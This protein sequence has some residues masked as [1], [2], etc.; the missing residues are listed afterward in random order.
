M[1]AAEAGPSGPGGDWSATKLTPASSWSA[2][3]NTGEFS[4]SYPMRV[5]PVRG[6]LVPPVTIGYNSGAVDGKTAAD[7][8]QASWIG[9]G[10]SYW[11][12]F[13]E[14]K[15]KPCLD[16]GHTSGDL[17]WGRNNAVLSL[18]G[19]STELLYDSASQSWRPKNDDGTKVERLTGASN[20]DNDGEYWRV[21]TMEGVQYIFGKD[22]PDDWSSGK[23][24][25]NSAWTVPVFGDDSG[26]PCYDSTFA[27]AWCRQAWRWNLDHVIDPHQ[28]TITY[29]YAKETNHYTRVGQFEGGTRYDSG[30]TLTRIDYGQRQGSTY[31][32]PAPARVRF[33]TATRTDLP[34]DQICDDG[35]T[36]GLR[37]ASPTFFDRKRLTKVTTELLTD[38]AA[39]TYSPVDVYDLG[40]TYQ[41]GVLWLHTID[42]TGKDGTEVSAP[43]VLLRGQLMPNRVL[44][45]RDGTGINALPG[46][47]RPRL[48]SVSNGTGSTT[49]VSYTDPY[50]TPTPA[51]A[52]L[53]S[54]GRMPT[55]R[56]NTKQ[57]FPVK[58]RDIDGDIVNDWYHKY[59]AD[60]I[61]E[62]DATGGSRSQVTTY[63]YV[64]GAA[65]RYAEDDGLT[66]DRWRT[67]SQ[68]R[69]YAKVRTIAGD[70]QNGEQ[71]SRTETTYARGM[72]GN[73]QG[74]GNTPANVTVTDSK[75]LL[76][77]IEDRD[78]FA[79]SVIESRTFNGAFTD[80]AEVSATVSKPRWHRTV[81][82]TFNDT[83]TG[84]DITVH[85]GWVQPEWTK[86]RTRQ[87]D[88][89][90]AYVE[91]YTDYDSLGRT[92]AVDD[93]GD[94][95]TASDDTCTRTV[96]SD[97]AASGIV[98]RTQ[99]IRVLQVAVDC[100]NAASS[101][102]NLVAGDV[103]A[104]VKTRYDGGAYG[105]HPTRGD[106]TAIEKNTGVTDGRSVTVTAVTKVHDSYGRVTSETQV[107]DPATTNDDRTTTSTYTDSAEGWLRSSTVTTPP[108]SVG[109][110]APAGFTTTTTY[111]PA[112]GTPVKVV[113]P[114]GRT[115]EA[116]Y[117][118]LGRIVK[119][120]LPNNTRTSNPDRPSTTYTY[121][122]PTDDDPVSVTTRTLRKTDP[123]TYDT[124]V[125]LLD[126][127]LRPRQTQN[128]APGGGRL[129]SDTKYDSRGL[130]S[131]TNAP[132]V[133][134]GDPSGVLTS[135]DD[136]QVPSHTLTT[137]DGVGR[138]LATT[139]YSMSTQKWSTTHQYRGEQTITIPPDGAMPTMSITDAR[140]RTVETR[141]YKTT[142]TSGAYI[143]TKV[144]YDGAGRPHELR[145]AA[146]NV[147]RTTFD[148]QG[149]PATS[150][151]P[152]KGTTS[153]TYDHFDQV[154]TSTDARG[155]TLTRGYD[156]L[157]RLLQV[158]NGATPLTSYT[159]DTVPY[160]KGLPAT[161]TRHIGN[162]AYTTAITGYDGLY[163]TRGTTITIPA[164]QGALAGTYTT[165]QGY[166]F[167][168]S[169][170]TTTYPAIGPSTGGL[171]EEV[172]DTFYDDD[173]LPEWSN[174][175]TTYVA[176]T[177]YNSHGDVA[178]L[179]L[180]SVSDKFI[181]QT[182]ER[183]EATDRVTRATVK[184]QS[185]AATY[186]VETRYDYSDAGSITSIL[187]NTAGYAADRQCFT[188]DYA[189]RL[190]QAYTTTQTTCGTPTTSTIGGP[191]PY[192][193]TYEYDS[194]GE[195]VGNRTKEIQHAFTGGPATDTV[196]TYNYPAELG[197]T[198]TISPHGLNS[199]TETTG[200]QS[201][202]D[203]YT[204]DP[205]GNTTTR[206]G[207]KLTW[208]AEG[209]LAKVTDTSDN[210]LASFIY[211]AGGNRLI[212]KDTTGTTLYLPGQE[213][214]VTTTGA[215][216]P[217][218]YYA[219]G[220]Q[221][222][223][224]RTGTSTSSVQFL[225][226]N[227]Q[228]STDVTVNA[229]D[230]S[231]WSLR[232][233]GPFG[234]ERTNPVG[235]WPRVMDKGFVGGSK[236]T[237]TGLTHLGAREYD[238]SI[239]RFISVDPVFA[240]GD[241][242]TWNGFAYA[243]NNPIDFSDPDGRLIAC[244]YVLPGVR[245]CPGQTNP[246]RPASDGNGGAAYGGTGNY[247]GGGGYV[248]SPPP[249]APPAPPPCTSWT[250][251]FK[252]AGGAV[253]GF[254]SKHRATI[255]SVAVGVGCGVAIGWTGGGA[256]ACAAA[257][258]AVYG[259]VNHAQHTPRDQWTAGGFLKAGAVGAAVGVVT[260]G[261]FGL[262]G[263]VAGPVIQRVAPRIAAKVRGG[264]GGAGKGGSPAKGNVVAKT[265]PVSPKKPTTPS[266]GRNGGNTPVKCSFVPG[267]AVLM[268][269]GSSKPI[270]K[271]KVGEKV[272]ATD[273]ATGKSGPQTVLATFNSL[274]T[275]DLIKI[276]VDTDGD[277][278][279][280]T[281]SLTATDNH[282]FWL[283]IQE[284][285]VEASHL[286]PGM[287]LRTSAGTHVQITAI[288]AWSQRQS[289]HNLTVDKHHTYYVRAGATPV[290]VHNSNCPPKVWKIVDPD[291][292]APIPS[293]MGVE[294]GE[295]LADGSY[296]YIV[297]EDW[298]LR[299]VHNSDLFGY[300]IEAGHTSLSER[301]DVLMAGIF[302]VSDGVITSFNNHSGHYLPKD[303]KGYMPLE[304]V[305]RRAFENHGLPAPPAGAWEPW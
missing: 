266:K 178:Q 92:T 256:V 19:R 47:D 231:T 265:P 192:W 288:K 175:L 142:D 97:R 124:S 252:K 235:T 210:E 81:T 104:D 98:I 38:R 44:T 70:G 200:T 204:Y 99:P 203:L 4:W 153:V 39:G 198:G 228:G 129:V 182:F 179:S 25:T 206:P 226:P 254:I 218:R 262:V 164:S 48:V 134:S 16:D 298:T 117:D 146:G 61:I 82:R 102:P 35:E 302:K 53:Y 174:G 221:T 103:I 201:R 107:G 28:N 251:K 21:T 283:P 240:G 168:G 76:G 239:G 295:N 191:A 57:C 24:E 284:K 287:W 217:I 22:R 238:P 139:L 202:T 246:S 260:H 301:K 278:G 10:F 162:D 51:G 290:L 41:N 222:I 155:T 161:A 292:Q 188:Y 173:G 170:A 150:T 62:S 269:D 136:N 71:Q 205:T 6:D 275:K 65:W 241:P 34:D 84:D 255:A 109:G 253:G 245:H 171:P 207:Q 145:D 127:L 2:G 137:Y 285:W 115:G 225:V 144:A 54:A 42:Q 166:N 211:D 242:A 5:P 108:V 147:W 195:K 66:K 120:W 268:A 31:A 30:G 237:T 277:K 249:P 3:T 220:G 224:Y 12:G 40:H 177:I 247:A 272:V 271:I 37:K 263:K 27:D 121:T 209:N 20:G 86:A 74:S 165:S 85:G 94:P 116:E 280:K 113:D 183:D 250:C 95:S 273:T 149:R 185:S 138:P 89:T 274:G 132:Y 276:T 219:H 234:D 180:A 160:A 261:V 69:G 194:N 305:A 167:D 77:G 157:G 151:D 83:N 56:S 214:K 7:N 13:I 78:T 236:D 213:L 259:L 176:D 80:A 196:R 101:E 152:D 189:Q 297:R 112:R 52:C 32:T 45:G 186:D 122:F 300:S 140:G 299:A 63:Q 14:R 169:T 172:Y 18:E 159:Y 75:N 258:G 111:N 184:R 193:T 279:T 60:Q 106:D 123:V 55:P 244:G 257:S 36:C 90:D 233:F 9:D 291:E 282:P 232:R 125:E 304:E 11:P 73:Y 223:A 154:K 58:W 79:G 156:N 163:R 212:R 87:A 199:V 29:Y 248:A 1:L 67:W 243:A 91:T 15:Y 119:A 230:Q 216:Q 158:R 286:K 143:A 46:Y 96:Y 105:D 215:I 128:E 264:G 88:G 187:T 293:S 50:A 148:A 181:W 141:Q 43:Q 17:C 49:S 208:D 197:N 133:M 294:V 68:W 23:P 114:N 126:G 110:A 131:K 229:S 100:D 130:V 289:V 118:G 281:D 93:E 72:D 59:L 64:G 267:T 26:E 227:Y 33:D 303:T 270:E 135:A 8:S 190:T 296:H